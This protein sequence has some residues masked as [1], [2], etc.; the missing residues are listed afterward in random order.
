MCAKHHDCCHMIMPEEDNILKCNQD[1]K[2]LNTPFVIY[3][4]TESLL[5]KIHACD[6]NPGKSSTIKISNHIVCGY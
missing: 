3:G 5:E 1:K 6:K 4:D 2:S